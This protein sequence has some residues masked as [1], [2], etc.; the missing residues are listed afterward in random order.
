[1][2]R[3]GDRTVSILDDA[4]ITDVLVDAVMLEID[5]SGAVTFSVVVPA[6]A[7][8]RLAVDRPLRNAAL[9]QNRRNALWKKLASRL[10]G[11]VLGY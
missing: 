1:M 2:V 7:G 11:P 8:C 4:R 6:Q 5:P 3:A 10:P 9:D